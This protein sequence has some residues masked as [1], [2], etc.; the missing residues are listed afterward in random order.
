M[1]NI[2]MEGNWRG[3]VD[4]LLGQT[5]EIHISI[6]QTF[7]KPTSWQPSYGSHTDFYCYQTKSL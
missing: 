7:T 2:N 6:Y 3:K 5:Y 1:L 4:R